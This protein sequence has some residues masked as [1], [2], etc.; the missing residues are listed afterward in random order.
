MNGA[1]IGSNALVINF[2]WEESVQRLKRR[3]KQPFA[4]PMQSPRYTS[5]TMITT[6][7]RI[8]LWIVSCSRALCPMVCTVV[9]EALQ[10][11]VVAAGAVEDWRSTTQTI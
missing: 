4:P 2:Q 8:R 7:H 11:E 5:C 9:A 1:V 6:Q 3:G 10:G